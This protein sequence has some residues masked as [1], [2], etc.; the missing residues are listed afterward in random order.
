M[1]KLLSIRVATGFWSANQSNAVVCPHCHTMLGYGKV[2][3]F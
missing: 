1:E 3:Y 2:N